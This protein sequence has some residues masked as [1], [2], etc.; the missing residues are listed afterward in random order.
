M[1]EKVAL[2]FPALK[3]FFKV[4]KDGSRITKKTLFW[5]NFLRRVHN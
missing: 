3:F 1:R 2:N 5:P 4:T